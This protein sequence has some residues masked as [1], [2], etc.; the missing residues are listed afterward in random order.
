MRILTFLAALFWASLAMPGE[1]Q[2]RHTLTVN[3]VQRA[4]WLFEPTTRDPAAPLIMALH[5]GGMEPDRYVTRTGLDDVAE[6][7][8]AVILAPEG[9]SDSWRYGGTLARQARLYAGDDVAFFAALNATVI[10]AIA[11]PRTVIVGV[12]AGGMMGYRA[13]C[14]GLIEADALAVVAGTM[15]VTACPGAAGVRLLHVHGAIDAKVP[16]AG[17]ATAESAREANYRPVEAGLFLFAGANGCTI[18]LPASY[19]QLTPTAEEYRFTCPAGAEVTLVYVRDGGHD[20]FALPLLDTTA[21]VA[22]FL[23]QH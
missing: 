13:V 19:T 21:R 2:T 17:G 22:A 6:A 18:A 11:A 8:G 14:D 1:A 16:Y 20:W 9:L 12:S 7:M 15:N 10:P 3:G 4:Y 5:G 23:A